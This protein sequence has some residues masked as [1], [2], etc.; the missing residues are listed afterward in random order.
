[1]ASEDSTTP[2]RWGL[3]GTGDITNKVVR[4][5]RRSPRL[6][7]VA[8]GS[9]TQ[10]RA[11]EYA[12]AHD[13]PRAHGSY[14]ALL[15]DPDV[16]AVYIS[17]PNSLHHEW[18]MHALRAGKHVLCEKPYSTRVEDV[19]EAYSFAGEHGLVVSEGFMWRHHPQAAALK[20]VLPELGELQTIR[21][22]FAFVLTPDRAT[23]IRLRADLEG[24]AL[25]DVGCYCVS[26]AR[27][28]TGEEPEA[29]YGRAAWGPSG[30]DLR[31]T[32][33][34]RFPSGVMAEFTSAFT[35]DHRGL[36]AIGTE[37]SALLLDPWQ[38]DPATFVRNGEVVSTWHADDPN[39]MEVPYCYEFENFSAAVRGSADVLL[40]RD[41]AAGQARVLGALYESARTGREIA[42]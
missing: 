42:L 33:V 30:V 6:T 29:V 18:T 40:G 28:L 41:D 36:E 39:P 24:G 34:L 16:E 19:E 37:G 17:L 21:A 3:L 20:A 38:A 5:A 14:D 25:M 2:V 8:V 1:M 35:M 4:G 11:D 7:F 13:V 32:A 23:D 27:F 10:E 12:A 15:A 31:F 26:G 9:R 22:T